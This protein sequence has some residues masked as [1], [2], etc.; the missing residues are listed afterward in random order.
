[1]LI[2]S[3][4]HVCVAYFLRKKCEKWNEFLQCRKFQ[5]LCGCF[6]MSKKWKNKLTFLRFHEKLFSMEGGWAWF[7]IEC[8][9]GYPQ[10]LFSIVRRRALGFVALPVYLLKRLKTCMERSPI[11]LTGE[12][13]S[14]YVTTLELFVMF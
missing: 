6:S 3:L 12:K 2:C 14:N 9:K 8:G 4:G 7:P 11:N 1:M 5:V 10:N 13:G